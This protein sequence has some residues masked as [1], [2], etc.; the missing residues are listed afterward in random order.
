VNVGYRHL[1]QVVPLI[2][3]VHPP[4]I[5]AAA[6]SARRWSQSGSAGDRPLAAA[7]EGSAA[8]AVVGAGLRYSDGAVA[9][10]R[11][12][13]SADEEGHVHSTA[14]GRRRTERTGE[15]GIALRV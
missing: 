4:S 2:S 10:P 5:G 8:S 15:L 7:L 1:A 11:T 9:D 3:T 12:A 14:T 6:A 13:R